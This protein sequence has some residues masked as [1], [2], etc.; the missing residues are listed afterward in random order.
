MNENTY[1]VTIYFKDDIC[2]TY[3]D[4][5]EFFFTEGSKFFY[6]CDSKGS[7]EYVSSKKILSI[8][9]DPEE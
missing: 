6:I 4:I 5:T 9:I 1:K 3:K 7:C 8:S 2:S